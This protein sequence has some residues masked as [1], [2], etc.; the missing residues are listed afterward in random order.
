MNSGLH[1][2]L[3][4]WPCCWFNGEPSDLLRFLFVPV[5]VA[6]NF[7]LFVEGEGVGILCDGNVLGLTGKLILPF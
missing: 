3:V 5:G 1:D 4:T 6:L 7:T 2:I